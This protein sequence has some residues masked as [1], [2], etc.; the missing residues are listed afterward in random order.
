MG[1]HPT[2]LENEDLILT[3]NTCWRP[4]VPNWDF[5]GSKAFVH[6][7]YESWY[8]YS[9]FDVC[10]WGGFLLGPNLCLLGSGCQWVGWPGGGKVGKVRELWI[11]IKERKPSVSR[12]ATDNQP[13]KGH[14]P[15]L[16][17]DIQIFTTLV[18]HCIEFHW[19]LCGNGARPCLHNDYDCRRVSVDP[20]S[21]PLRGDLA[22][23]PRLRHLPS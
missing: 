16:A 17:L 1:T 3:K 11:L 2:I 7:I 10:W 20:R 23:A 12:Q 21:H 22:L 6:S 8:I 13:H 18:W 19:K 15:F 5:Y 4:K 14:H 9:L